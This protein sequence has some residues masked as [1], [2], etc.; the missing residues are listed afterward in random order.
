MES[1]WPPSEYCAPGLHMGCK[2]TDLSDA[3]TL[4]H[5]PVVTAQR[6]R[7]KLSYGLGHRSLT[8]FG[9]MHGPDGRVFD[10]P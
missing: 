5:G 4:K 2:T 10:Q 9:F 6:V 8:S 7:L 3:M 1:P